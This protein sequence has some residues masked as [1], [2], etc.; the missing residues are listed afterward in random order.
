MYGDE[1]W[2]AT[3]REERSLR[4]LE[5]RTLRV[6]FGLTLRKGQDADKNS[7]VRNFRV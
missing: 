2:F 6:M 5:N 3:L 4:V 7:I 1:N